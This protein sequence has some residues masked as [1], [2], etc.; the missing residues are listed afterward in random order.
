M[1]QRAAASSF[2]EDVSARGARG[3]DVP[4]T[5]WQ[6]FLKRFADRHRGALCRAGL[7][8]RKLPLHGA[9]IV[10]R[11]DGS[12]EILVTLGEPPFMLEPYFVIH[13]V[14]VRVDADDD[15]SLLLALESREGAAL[16][17]CFDPSVGRTSGPLTLVG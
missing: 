10:L 15:G 14:R 1:H 6:S 7:G 2:S 8:A 13:P 12:A 4:A 5:H 17:L 3:Y 9:G 11:S 16:R